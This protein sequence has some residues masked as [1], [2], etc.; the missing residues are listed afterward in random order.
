MDRA[1]VSR[2]RIDQDGKAFEGHTKD[3]ALSCRQWEPPNAVA[4]GAERRGHER[5]HR[6]GHGHSKCALVSGGGAGP[7]NSWNDCG[8]HLY[9]TRG[10]SS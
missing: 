7:Q 4:L 8:A 3:F 2:T 1:K 9:A 5:A 6:L 10:A